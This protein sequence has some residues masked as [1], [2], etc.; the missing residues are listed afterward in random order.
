M[1]GVVTS[2]HA[3]LLTTPESETVLELSGVALPHRVV[4]VGTSSEGVLAEVL[5]DR[6]DEVSEG[7]MLGSLDFAVQRAN[8]QLALARAQRTAGRE[9]AQARVAD[10]RRRFERNEVLF[11]EGILTAEELEVH[12]TNLVLEELALAKTEE[13]LAIALLEY[14][15]AA[16]ILTLGTIESPMGGI[17]TERFL[18]PGELLSRSGQDALVTIAKID[19]LIIEVNTPIEHYGDM[20]IGARAT[21]LMTGFDDQ[22]REAEV[23]SVDPVVDT[24]SDTFRVRLELSNPGNRLPAGLRCT[25]RFH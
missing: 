14:Q 25:V 3:G 23:T 19:P 20:Q 21:V 2:T 11:A 18:S 13:E 5:V 24:A 7:Q 22:E 16:A 17:V 1:A 12:R 4:R 9:I 6:G 10:A 15:R 8:A